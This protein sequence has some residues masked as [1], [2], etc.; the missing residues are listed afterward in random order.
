MIAVKLGREE[1]DCF[2]YIIYGFLLYGGVVRWLLCFFLF[3][4]FSLFSAVEL[5][6][7]RITQEAFFSLVAEKRVSLLTNHTGVTS[8]LERTSALFERLSAQ[9]KLTLVSILVPEHGFWGEILSEKEVKTETTARGVPVFS[10]YGQTSRPTDAMLAD[11]DCLVCDLQD[12]GCRSYSW[13]TT[14]FLVIEEAAKKKIPVVVLDRPNPL[15]GE[16]VD[17]PMVEEDRGALFGHIDVPYCHGMTIGELSKLFVAERK[18]DCALSVV[19]MQGWSREK[20][21]EQTGLSWIPTSPN[22]PEATTPFYFPATGLLGIF[23]SFLYLGVGDTLPFRLVAAP[24]IDGEELAAALNKDGCEGFCFVPTRITP[25]FG[26]FSHISCGG[27]FLVRTDRE[28]ARP[29]RA[30]FWILSTIKRL[31]P[32]R[33]AAALQRT[34]RR[35]AYFDNA[36]GTSRIFDLLEKEERPYW[37]MVCLHVEERRLFLE[38]RKQYLLPD[39]N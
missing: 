3:F 25:Y 35:R 26:S 20:S 17:G 28:K 34:R 8:T 27:V 6:A 24:W 4:C 30:L 29:V 12:P 37:P 38:R 19:P 10:L 13:T 11:V 22:I 9:K 21:Y 23:P 7:D 36:C 5:G 31:Y 33:F 16:Y 18:I 2:W 39:Y 15:G 1:K 14:L 32:E